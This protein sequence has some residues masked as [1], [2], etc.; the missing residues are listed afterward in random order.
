MSIIG[1]PV[2]FYGY[3]FPGNINLMVV[4]LYAAKKFKLLFAPSGADANWYK[5]WTKFAY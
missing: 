2:G 5:G 4:E 3:L 1:I